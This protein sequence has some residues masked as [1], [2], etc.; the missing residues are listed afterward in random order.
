[1]TTIVRRIGKDELDQITYL[2]H[3]FFSESS[4]LRRFDPGVWMRNWVS[5]LDANMGAI[6]GLVKAD[7]IVGVL[8][9]IKIPDI[10]SGDLTAGELFWFVD[11]SHRGRGLTLFNA[12]EK[13]AREEGCAYV[14][15]AH[16]EGLMS[17]KLQRFYERRGYVP[18]ETNYLKEVR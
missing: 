4:H 10:N 13:W 9:A 8:G 2:G 18:I 16:L 7:K 5:L 6:F 1:M 14:T 3:K 15:M 12:F 17:E 11:Q